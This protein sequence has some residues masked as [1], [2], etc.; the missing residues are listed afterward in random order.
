MPSK[1][2]RRLFAEAYLPVGFKTLASA[3]FCDGARVCDPQQRAGIRRVEPTSAFASIANGCGSKTR[4]PH[5]GGS[6]GKSLVAALCERRINIFMGRFGGHRPPLQKKTIF[7]EISGSLSVL[8]FVLLMA[9]GF[10]TNDLRAATPLAFSI[11]IK[12]GLIATPQSGRL[13]MILSRTNKSDLRG[14]LQNPGKNA[15]YVFARDVTGFQSGQPMAMDDTASAFP[16][17]NLWQIPAGK[18]FAEAVLLSNPDVFSPAAPG[19]L[20]SEVRPLEIIPGTNGASLKGDEA[21]KFILSKQ[22]PPEKL[23]PGTDLVKFIKVP[24][25]L[26][27]DFYGRPMFLRAGLILPR[28]YASDTNRTYPLWVHIGGLDTHYTSVS[29]QMSDKNFHKMWLATNTPEMIVLQLDGE[30]PLGDPYQVNS[31]NLGPYGDAVMQE[32]LPEVERTY[33]A[34][35]RPGARFLSGVS[36]GGW[37]SLA[38]QIFYPEDFN[39]VWS[40]CPDPVDFRA[41]ELINIYKDEN[42]YVNDYGV[43]RPSER[44]VNGDIRLLMRRE[45]GMENVLGHGGSFTTG[46]GQWCDWNAV[47]SPRGA[48][49]RPVPIWDPQTGEINHTVA[50][51]WKKYD[52]RLVLEKNWKT[53]GPKLKGKLHIASGD[54]DNFFLNNAVH[55]LDAFLSHADPPYGGRVVFG[56][57]KGHGWSDVTTLQMM[58]EMEAAAEKSNTGQ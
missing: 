19:N 28:N 5:L 56:P 4:A 27:S 22:N 29:G 14:E 46:G 54:A 31:E 17:T 43:E 6:P 51:A 1:F 44:A 36:T 41:F 13:L 50:E 8:N 12:E 39:G 24:S 58:K 30:G 7:A 55:L 40:S 33:R 38:L 2:R 53:L 11:T 37:V 49:G 21:A 57:G 47:Y 45:V 32:L 23:P 48:D 42:A 26:L 25:R 35:G 34:A 20:Y 18:Y 52:L 9:L 10:F 16:I 3:F 15:P